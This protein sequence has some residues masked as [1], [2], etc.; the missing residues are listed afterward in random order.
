MDPNNMKFCQSCGMP[1]VTAED[2]GTEA[3]GSASQDYCQY[4]YQKGAFTSSMTMEEMIDFCVPHMVTGHPGMTAEQA[5]AQMQQF[6]PMLLRGKK[7]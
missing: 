7:Q 4:C 5:K 6:F 3:D 1:L 2:H